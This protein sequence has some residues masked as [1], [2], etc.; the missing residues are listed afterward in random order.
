[1]SQPRS[2]AATDPERPQAADPTIIVR[3]WDLPLRLF[4]WALAALVA[5]SVATAYAGGSWMDWHMRS[6]YAVLALLAFRIA[7]GFAGTRHARFASFVKGP[8]AL[9]AY[10]RSLGSGAH[11]VSVGHNPLG[12]LSVLALIAIVLAQVGTGLFANDDILTEGPLAKLV[13]KAASDRATTIHYWNQWLLYALVAMHLL[14]VIVHRVRF[15]DD[16]VGP[17]IAGA[18]RLPARYAGED[19]GPTP[20]GRA[21]VVAALAAAFAWYVTTRI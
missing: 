5:F 11:P 17:M 13:S 7:W 4:H 20:W 6:G 14:A 12:A 18:K 9:M 15:R 21:L 3:V 1:M 16:L 2:D 19:A 8:A 10:A